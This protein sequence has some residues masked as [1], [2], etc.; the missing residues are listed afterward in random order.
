MDLEEV[1][2]VTFDV[3][4]R[5]EQIMVGTGLDIVTSCN[6]DEY[7]TPTVELDCVAIGIA[8]E[9]EDGEPLKYWAYRENIDPG[10]RYYPDGSGDTPSSDLIPLGDTHENMDEAIV[11]AVKAAV[12]AMIREFFDRER[13]E[14]VGI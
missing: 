2:Q 4:K 8:I 11:E 7:T 12:E 13:E 14:H 10:V 5:I 3:S 9:I 6:C 1:R